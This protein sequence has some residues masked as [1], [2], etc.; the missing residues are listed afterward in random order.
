MPITTGK[1][2]FLELLR[3]EGVSLIFGNPGTTELPLMDALAADQ[4]MRYV[5]C[6]QEAV[7]LAMADGYSRASRS[8]AAVNIH[9]AP[10]LGN[11]MGMLYDAWKAGTPLLVT[12][13]QQAASFGIT[14]PMLWADL[15]PVARP[16]VKWAVEIQSVN[17]L[18]RVIHRAAK[19]ALTPPTGPVFISLP[20]DVLD[21]EAD[22]DLGQPTRIPASLRGDRGA[23]LEA[24]QILAAATN[25]VIIAGDAVVQGDAQ[26]ELVDLVESLGATVYLEG[27]SSCNAF[28]TRHPQFGGTIP[29][30]AP[31][32]HSALE[33]HDVL[34]SVGGD[35]FTLTLPSDLDPVPPGLKIIHLDIDPWQ[36]GK[37]VHASP[38]IFGE[39]KAVLPELTA[40]LRGAMTSGQTAR[41]TERG[42]AV[43]QSNAGKLAQLEEQAR[44]AVDVSPVLP[45]AL[46][47]AIAALL[48]PDAII[49]DEVV[50]SADGLR[51]FLPND[52]ADS[53]YGIRGGGIGW[54]IPAAIGAALARPNAP[55]VALIGDGSAMYTCQALW[56]AAHQGANVTFIIYANRSYRI[57]KQ[58]LHAVGGAAAQADTFIGM[59]LDNPSI[60]FVQLA[61]SMGIPGKR[62]STIADFNE[63]FSAALAESGPRLI[64]VEVD[65][66]FKPL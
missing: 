17:D 9:A 53:F 48:P 36:L 33:P 62:V 46:N 27:E 49:I 41:A 5:L 30:L 28:P 52:D 8:L 58:R 43:R 32:I 34:F 66:T 14:E 3:Q 18:P 10:G 35:L 22:L 31:S 1:R 37:N 7:A 16:F 13:G 20:T 42:H 54:G 15:P 60:G 26:A 57:L 11:A 65:A 23:I 51:A 50:S 12:A 40:A 63:A 56:T 61:A 29:R 38:A 4:D 55:I 45:V 21:A 19:I 2:A 25:P 39:P 24:A 59:E 47:H 64:E 44:A 6:L